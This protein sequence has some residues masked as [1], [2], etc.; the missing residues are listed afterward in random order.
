MRSIHITPQVAALACVVDK[1]HFRKCLTGVHFNCATA[2]AT[3][4]KL[5]LRAPI[6]A[7]GEAESS[8]CIVP[9]DAFAKSVYGTLRV[10]GAQVEVESGNCVQKFAPISEKFPDVDA[11][12]PTDT[13]PMTVAL[14]VTI[15]ENL[16]KAAKKA[17][18]KTIK[19]G[20]R[21]AEQ[22][23][24]L[25]LLDGKGDPVMDGIIMPVKLPEGKSGW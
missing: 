16:L 15:L 21:G 19:F 24:N 22:P 12:F 5:L 8:S 11:V 10:D 25:A 1:K 4:G 6:L 7:E 20:F 23:A 17:D 9:A 18:A 2:T 13:P 14:S 3:D